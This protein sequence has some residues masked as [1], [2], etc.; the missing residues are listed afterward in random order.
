MKSSWRIVGVSLLLAACSSAPT[1]YHTLAQIHQP[2]ADGGGCTTCTILLAHV[3]IPAEVDRMQLLVHQD[4]T[5][6]KVYESERWAASLRDQIP[7]ILIG[8][9]RERLPGAAITG[10]RLLTGTQAPLRLN[11]DVEELDAVAGK[12]A[13]V[14]VRWEV[15]SADRSTS[16]VGEQISRQPLSGTDIDGVVLAWSRALAEV[17][18]AIAASIRCCPGSGGAEIIR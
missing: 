7:G 12:E 16:Q 18:S 17:S 1:H 6:L 14:R 10:D 11:V 3:A 8:D 2:A 13:T 5:R 9:L 15:T 4:P